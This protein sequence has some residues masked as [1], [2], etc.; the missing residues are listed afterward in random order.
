[1]TLYT[2]TIQPLRLQA[3]FCRIGSS[4]IILI[5]RKS[6][7]IASKAAI[8]ETA[9][10]VEFGTPSELNRVQS[11][12]VNFDSPRHRRMIHFSVYDVT[13]RRSN[14]K[15]TGFEIP[16]SGMCSV[17]A[18]D[19]ICEKKVVSFRISG[20]P[21]RMEVIFR[22]HPSSSPPPPL[23]LGAPA[24]DS[25][26]A[27]T[28]MERLPPQV[29]E[30][31][32]RA[33]LL[34]GDGEAVEMDAVLASEIAARAALLFPSEDDLAKRVAVLEREV[35]QLEY[36]AQYAAKDKV[37]SGSA[38]FQALQEEVNHWQKFADE[39]DAKSAHEA[40]IAPI[41]PTVSK[42]LTARD[43]AMIAE[44]EDQLAAAQGKMR[45]LEAL[46]YHRDVTND[47]IPLIEEIE[48]LE[49]ILLEIKGPGEET[50]KHE[51]TNSGDTHVDQWERLSGDLYDKESLVEQLK[52]TVLALNR[53][54]FEPY[55]AGIEAGFMEDAPRELPFVRDNKR[56]LESLQTQNTALFGNT[57]STTKAAE[58]HAVNNVGAANLLDDLFDIAPVQSASAQ[59]PQAEVLPVEVA[60]CPQTPQPQE[61][62]ASYIP[63]PAASVVP[64]WAQKQEASP[65]QSLTSGAAEAAKTSAGVSNANL[66]QFSDSKEANPPAPS[67]VDSA[68]GTEKRGGLDALGVSTQPPAPE[69]QTSTST[70]GQLSSAPSL[71]QKEQ[72]KPAALS[73]GSQ[74]QPTTALPAEPSA[75]PQPAPS[76]LTPLQQQ[77]QQQQSLHPASQQVGGASQQQVSPGAGVPPYVR[78]PPTLGEIPFT[79]FYNIPLMG[80]ACPLD[81]YLD[82]KTPTRGTELTILNHA[83][84]DIIIGGVELKQEDVHSTSPTSSR[85]IPTRRWPQEFCVPAGDS[86]ARCV[87][88][89]HPSFPRASSLFMLVVVYVFSNGSYTPYA[90]RF[91]V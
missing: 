1:M 75:H 76:L 41:L 54:Q 89:L 47:I 63:P 30:S 39:I 55:P 6:V 9:G 77:N 58:P 45:R 36:D 50:S 25:A 18:G 15:L 44:I 14:T 71:E 7:E 12:Q 66:L 90:A 57:P 46:Q 3:Y 5:S 91:S 24:A 2:I 10:E 21:G 27:A 85:T 26:P 49:A 74:P 40:G 32:K 62:M 56:R 69:I 52:C 53:L 11:F 19:S 64:V 31:L 70:H 67:A 22:M 84:H 33:G 51:L 73:P 86:C 35:A 88:A 82:G 13:N 4:Y 20:K 38:A 43:K 28:G 79:A 37:T 17:F 34:S 61:P 87:I 65:A 23:K 16:L 81:I 60:P 48:H 78:R 68:E 72:E 59:T 83:N 42:E 29:V 8:C 80:R